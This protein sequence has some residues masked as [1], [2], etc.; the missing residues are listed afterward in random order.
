MRLWSNLLSSLLIAIVSTINPTIG[1][2]GSIAKHI[3]FRTGAIWKGF[4]VNVFSQFVPGG[5]VKNLVAGMISDIIVAS[6]LSSAVNEA[7]PCNDLALKCDVCE[8]YTRYY[9]KNDG[10]IKCKD[11]LEENLD[12]EITHEDK[13]YVLRNNVYRVQE[14]LRYKNSLIV[15]APTQ[16]EPHSP[17]DTVPYTLDQPEITQ[18]YE[19]ATMS[20][21]IKCKPCKGRGYYR[22]NRK[23]TCTVCSGRGRIEVK[24]KKRDYQL[25]RPCKGHGY[26]GRNRKEICETCHG[27]GIVT[28]VYAE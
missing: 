18:E 28:K 8:K 25:C 12:K 6:S 23:D 24:G 21:I 2:L 19:G 22:P 15:N 3:A 16:P 14:K 26:Y 27:L 5:F 13:I 17:K 1:F 7:T 4:V 9:V 10:L 20:F 11:C